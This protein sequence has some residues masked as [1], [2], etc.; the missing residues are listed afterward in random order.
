MVKTMVSCRFSLKPIHWSIH[1]RCLETYYIHLYAAETCWNYAWS[2]GVFESPQ[3]LEQAMPCPKSYVARTIQNHKPLS[4]SYNLQTQ[5][6]P[7]SCG[8]T[9]PT[10]FFSINRKHNR[11]IPLPDFRCPL[12][13]QDFQHLWMT[14]TKLRRAPAWA[15]PSTSRPCPCCDKAWWATLHRKDATYQWIALQ[16]GPQGKLRK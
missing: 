13:L 5:N 4:G 6:K 15:F 10:Y 8:L 11:C 2:S 1:F 7:L 12:R 9:V 16:Q 14:W 3:S